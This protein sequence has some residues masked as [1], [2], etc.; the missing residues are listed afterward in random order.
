[1][2]A[3]EVERVDLS[4]LVADRV[5]TFQQL[6]PSRQLVLRPKPGLF[7]QGN[8]ERLSQLLDKLLNNAVEHSEPDAEIRVAL[9]H[10]NDDW[11]ELRVENEGDPLPEDR[12]RIFEAFVSSQS[13][14]ENLGLGLFV[15][16]SI[17][18]NHQGHIT[19]EN[20]PNACGASFVLRLPKIRREA[21]ASA[22]D[23]SL[24]PTLSSSGPSPAEA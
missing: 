15:A 4:A 6:H 8:E 13:R 12:E 23:D 18:R 9:R 17:A 10:S 21:Q 16:Q 3:D 20:L 5:L 2:A 11:F 19:A 7:I 1:L 22:R 14:P 24:Q